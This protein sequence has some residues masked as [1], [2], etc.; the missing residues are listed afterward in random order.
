MIILEVHNHKTFVKSADSND[1][2]LIRTALTVFKQKFKVSRFVDTEWEITYL[3]SYRDFSFPTAYLDEV[4]KYCYDQNIS[5]NITDE[6][7]YKA[8]HLYKLTIRKTLDLRVDQKEAYEA[9]KDSETGIFSMPT[10]TGKSRVIAKT[11][12]YRKVR[13]LICVPTTNLQTSMVNLCEKLFGKARVGYEVPQDLLEKMKRGIIK[14]EGD[15]QN[16]FDGTSKKIKVDL[17]FLKPKTKDEIIKKS[18]ALD[19]FKQTE[20]QRK[21]KFS[22]DFLEPKKDLSPEDQFIKEKKEQKWAKQ[23]EKQKDRELNKLNGPVKY[24]DIYV[25]C[26][27]SLSKLPQEFLNQFEMVIIDEAHHS[28]GNQI[29]D[30][31][32]KLRKACYRYFFTATPWRDHSADQKLLISAIGTKMI[33]EVSA[34][35]SIELGSIAKPEFEQLHP[36]GSKNFIDKK[37]KWRDILNF[38]II[39]NAARNKMIVDLAIK[40]YKMGENI[41]ISVDEI[42]H[43][44]MLKQRFLDQGI[45]VD[46][47]HGQINKHKNDEIILKVG[48]RK[49]G[50]SLG[51]MSVGE[52]TDM[53]NLTV[54]I[55]ASG[56]KS[57]IRL[58]QRIGRGA[59]LGTELSKKSFKVFDFFD[60]FHPTLLRHSIAR[61]RIY[62]DYFKDWAE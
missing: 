43:I 42:T 62:E 12:E 61:K 52:G 4:K 25:F 8:A 15:V 53:P 16:Q 30:C 49:T 28:S 2:E 13:T 46:I 57:S 1:L 6:R 36:P 58:I 29:R 3:L 23:K 22:F 17:D 19:G 20:D 48:E 54:I 35:R 24:K 34:E 40:Q 37:S 9:M 11:I 47:I 27:A 14:S 21:P 60:W 39:G 51:T 50:I 45:E 18:S 55:L 5:L 33:Y 32:L 38:G 26:N 10:A 41:F 31:L 59:R 7:K 56:G 44:D